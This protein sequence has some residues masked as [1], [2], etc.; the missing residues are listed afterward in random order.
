MSYDPQQFVQYINFMSWNGEEDIN[1][2]IY[3]HETSFKHFR[4]CER[5]DFEKVKAGHLFDKYEKFRPKSLICMNN[6]GSFKMNGT[7]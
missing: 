3:F 6:V 2:R 5:A 7:F 1:R 4:N